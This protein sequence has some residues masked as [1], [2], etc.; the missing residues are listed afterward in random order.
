[1]LRKLKTSILT[2]S[3]L[4][5]V[6]AGFSILSPAFVAADAKADACDGLQQVDE[7]AA[8]CGS[9]SGVKELVG[10]VVNIL[11]IVVGIVAVIAI[12]V[13]GLRF[14]TSGGNSNSIAAARSSLIYA[15][16]GLVVAALAQ[17][18]VHF[19][20]STTAASV[21]P[22]PSNPSITADNPNCK[23]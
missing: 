3:V 8:S 9:S 22:C 18:L 16:I 15:L 13:S 23:D 4:I 7:N 11:S 12:I 20:L 5:T 10:S 17:V 1:M 2:M 21:D 6:G 14:V 19:V